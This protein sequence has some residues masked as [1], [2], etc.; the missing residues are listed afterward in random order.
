MSFQNSFLITLLLSMAVS[1]LMGSINTAIIIVRLRYNKDIRSLGSGNAGFTN[2]MRNFGKVPA[3]FTMA[4]DLLKGMVAIGLSYLLVFIMGKYVNTQLNGLLEN[5]IMGYIAAIFA[6]L[7]HSFPIF[8]NFKG[9]KGVA[10]TCA[11]MLVI[12]PILCVILVSLFLVVFLISR[13]VSL[14]SIIAAV[15]IPVS[16]YI[17]LR[18]EN[19]EN[20]MVETCL[21]GI[22]AIMLILMHRKNIYRIIKGTEN[23]FGNKKT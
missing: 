1:Y 4:G 16:T 6:I 20:I 14:G 22:I 12:E 15:G 18:M 5:D 2:V 17:K 3:A 13:M 8:Y 21:A 11:S 9:G 10:V 23:K 19:N 7:G